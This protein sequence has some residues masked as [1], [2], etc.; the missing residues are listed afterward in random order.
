MNVAKVILVQSSSLTTGNTER[1]KFVLGNKQ[2]ITFVVLELSLD[3]LTN[4][5][6]L[7]VKISGRIV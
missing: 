5:V 3:T 2:L 7:L 1:C 4:K 6:Y